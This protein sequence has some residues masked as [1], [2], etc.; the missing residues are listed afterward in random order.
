[1]KTSVKHITYY[2][3]SGMMMTSCSATD[4]MT[5]QVIETSQPQAKQ[6]DLLV[7]L[8]NGAQNTRQALTRNSAATASFPGMDLLVCIPYRTNGASV[9]AS[10]NPLID[11]VGANEDNVAKKYA[12]EKYN[13]YYVD[14]CHLMTGTDRMLVYGKAKPV[15]EDPKENGQLSPLPNIRKKT[16]DI[17]FS[18]TSIRESTEAPAEAN[19]LANYMTSIANTTNWSTTEDPTLKSYYLDFIRMGSEGAGLMSGAAANIKAFVAALRSL[20]S[21]RGDALSAAIIANIDNDDAIEGSTYPRS[22]GLP[23]GA[24][25]IRWTGSAFSVRTTTT[26]LDNINGINRYTYPAELMFFADSPIRTSTEKVEKTVYENAPT[27]QLWSAFLN[28][29]YTGSTAVN[30]NTKAVAVEN[31][32]QYGVAK[33]NLTLTGMSTT[34]RDAKDEIVSNTSMTT[35][36]LTG[37]IIGGQH[38]VGFNMK[39]QGEQTDVDGRF[40]YETTVDDSSLATEGYKTSTL[41]LQS[42]DNE[43]VPV[44]LEFENNT[45][46]AFTGKD[47]TVYPNTRFYLIA[48]TDPAGK[49]TGAYA[50]RVFTQDYTTTMSMSVTSLAKAYT[51]MPDLLA[52]R[53]EIGVQ[54]VTKWIQATT[55]NVE[56]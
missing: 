11:L 42:Y 10:D 52:P 39:P 14:R 8:G 53:L 44:I 7:S 36:P 46:N 19:A 15:S 33:L 30:T 47:G 4:D 31:P 2:L 29:Y 27:N 51:C 24:A 49:G 50:G 13:T 3:L 34:L 23:D 16:A 26:T 48:M 38:T 25:V 45:G 6:V 43:K 54:V 55:T 56:L 21:G 35:L 12:E 22:I 1:M 9:T 32:I 5:E 17:Q 20:L 40:I 41:V 18:L 37:V 28:T